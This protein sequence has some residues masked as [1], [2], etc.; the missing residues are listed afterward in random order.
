MSNVLFDRPIAFQRVF[1]KLGVGITGALMLSQA[2][3]WSNRTKDPDGWFYKDQA[4]WEEETGLTR[5]EQE[6]ARK[7]LV[8]LGVL[9]ERKKGIPCRLFY[10]VNMRVLSLQVNKIASLAESAILE[11]TKAPY[12]DG[13]KRHSITENTTEITTEIN[14]RSQLLAKFAQLWDTWPTGLGEKGSRKNAENVF[15]K[16]KP[17]DELFHTIITSR[18]SQALSK[19]Q[20][21][22]L[23][24][25]A[26]P[27]QHVERWLRNRRWEDEIESPQQEQS[28]V[29]D[30]YL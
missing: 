20:A 29:P 16:L 23:G 19:S 30:Y 13:G 11:C 22:A 28:A 24:E 9:Q 12:S 8:D 10:R 14:K 6:T 2:V 15:L 1:V 4:E 7:K 3:Y 17:D 26:S 18:N 5:R 21:K 27:F 25:F